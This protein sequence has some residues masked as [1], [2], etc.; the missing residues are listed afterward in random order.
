MDLKAQLDAQIE[1]L[2]QTQNALLLQIAAQEGHLSQILNSR[3]YQFAQF[4]SRSLTRL[5][6]LLGLVK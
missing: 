2:N 5:K 4:L 1:A 6:R 3:S